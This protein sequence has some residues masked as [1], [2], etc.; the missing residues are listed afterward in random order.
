[1]NAPALQLPTREDI[2][3][4]ALTLMSAPQVAMPVKHLFAA[5]VYVR[6]IFMPAETFV[7]G[8]EH[9]TEHFNV[10]LSGKARVLSEGVVKDIGAGEVFVS[11]AGAQ[12]VLLI[13]E[14]MRFLT[15]H[16]NPADATDV[17]ELEASLVVKSEAYLQQADLLKLKEGTQ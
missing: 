13:M 1:V 4:V 17:D 6:E 9:K 16:A 10:V 14:D 15:I 7:I 12:K 3:T 2:E 5:G 11:G 8:F